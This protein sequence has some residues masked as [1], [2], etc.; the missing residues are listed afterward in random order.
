MNSEPL[1]E[2]PQE[3][4]IRRRAAQNFGNTPRFENGSTEGLK[5]GAK[6]RLQSGDTFTSRAEALGASLK[7]SAATVAAQSLGTLI[8]AEKLQSRLQGMIKVTR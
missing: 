2:A 3:P 4:A 5:F 8:L 6:S 1:L 7:P